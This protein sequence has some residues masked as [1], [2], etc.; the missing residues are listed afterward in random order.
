ME[1]STRVK[2][3]LEQVERN[4]QMW[5]SDQNRGRIPEHLWQQAI[6]LLEEYTQT[7]VCKTLQLNRVSFKKK[8]SGVKSSRPAR[9]PEQLLAMEETP[10][11]TMTRVEDLHITAD[12]ASQSW[13]ASIRRPDGCVLSIEGNEQTRLDGLISRFCGEVG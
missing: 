13:T 6:G 7:R 5:R 1:T 4:F 2:P 11:F 3:S 8:A 10:T 9:L 12:A